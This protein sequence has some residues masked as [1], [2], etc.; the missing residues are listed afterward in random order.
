M[1]VARG[2][3]AL[4]IAPPVST[5]PAA[6]RQGR[7]SPSIGLNTHPGSDDDGWVMPPPV[8]LNDGTRIQL[9]KDGEG[10]QA[11]YNA[12]KAA[13]ERVCLEVYIF[14]SDETGRAFADLLSAK[15]REGVRVYLIYDSFGSIYSD[16]AMFE[17]MRRS[18]VRV[19]EFHPIFPWETRFSWR[20]INRDHRKVLVIDRDIAG[21]AGLNIGAEYAGSWVVPNPAA[22]CEAWRDNAIGIVGPGAQ[23]FLDAFARTWHYVTHGGRIRRAEFSAN[24]GGDLGVLASVPTMNSPLRPNLCKL[25]QSARRS[26]DLSMAYFAP[27]D[28]LIDELCKAA[29]RGVRVRL[30]LP[31]RC[32][33]PLVRVAAR[34][35]YEMLLGCGIE[36]YERQGVILHSKT[37]VVDGHTTVMGSMNLDYRSIEYNCEISTIIRSRE[38]G[39]NMHDLFE[40]DVGFS[41]KIE[42]RQWRRRPMWDRFV[43]WAVSRARYLL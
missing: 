18:G 38:F 22:P 2:R 28:L 13:K 11:A 19:Q 34:S 40:N 24:L 41:E 12:I 27:D 14:S 25:M 15:A 35:F 20:P 31:G 39:L 37:L 6:R 5:V 3:S 32:D 30:V 8:R 1:E 29:G 42:L 43:Q 4:T 10:L 26:I 16:R 23:L 33:V 7:V 36:I 17:R 9:Y 21:I